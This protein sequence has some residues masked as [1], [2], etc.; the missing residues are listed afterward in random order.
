MLFK[1]LFQL[2]YL[3]IFMY[4]YLH[5]D[6]WIISS[7]YESNRYFIFHAFLTISLC[8][9]YK[10][11]IL[12]ELLYL[13]CMDKHNSQVEIE[14]K[15][16]AVRVEK[17]NW[18]GCNTKFDSAEY[19]P[20]CIIHSFRML[21]CLE[22]RHVKVYFNSKENFCV[23][24]F[25]CHQSGNFWNALYISNHVRKNLKIISSFLAKV[26]RWKKYS[27][28]NLTVPDVHKLQ[29]MKQYCFSCPFNNNS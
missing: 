16:E 9:R 23:M 5:I 22:R 28:S 21:H 11:I 20:Y 13:F 15:K 18:N 17:W 8:S 4:L 7:N 14:D 27:V 1:K 19:R 2:W 3:F 25:V 24:W 6:V 10:C 26:F 29:K 12:Y